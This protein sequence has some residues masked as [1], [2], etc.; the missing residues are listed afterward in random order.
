MQLKNL[1]PPFLKPILRSSY[2]TVVRSSAYRKIVHKP[3]SREELHQ[4]W[5]RP[6][7]DL[8]N[9]PQDYLKG[10]ERSQFLVNIVKKHAQ[11]DA[12]ILEIGC[13]VGRNLNYLHL[14]GFRRL[15]AIE[16]NEDAIKL[17][18]ESFPQMA[19]QTVIHHSPVEE[20]IKTFSDGEFDVVYSM[21]VLEHIHTESE[22]IFTEIVR[23]TDKFLI[24]IEDEE[25]LSWR[26]FPRNYRKSFEALGMKQIEEFNCGNIEGLGGGFFARVF[27]KT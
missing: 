26:H 22:W 19:S 3:R 24:T 9:V 2:Y 17:L 23:V 20:V 21:A 10:E 8:D 15:N 25:N 18:K 16:I 7:E 12:K 4:Y 14:A 27:K 1:I 6:A 13:N 11:E 5:R